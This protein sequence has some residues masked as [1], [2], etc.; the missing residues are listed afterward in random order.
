MTIKTDKSNFIKA[1]DKIDQIEKIANEINV[2]TWFTISVQ[3]RLHEL[4]Y[5]RKTY[6]FTDAQML[7]LQNLIN[8]R[9]ENE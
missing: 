3:D 6:D 1:L 9:G 4:S 2:S 5:I 7:Y 8:F